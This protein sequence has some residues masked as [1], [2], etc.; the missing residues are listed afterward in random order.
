MRDGD[1]ADAGTVVSEYTRGA[2]GE[3]TVFDGSDRSD[4]FV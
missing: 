2:G 4:G 3:T 1:K